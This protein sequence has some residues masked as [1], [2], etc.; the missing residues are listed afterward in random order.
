VSLGEAITTAL[1]ELRAHAESMMTDTVRLE[2][3]TGQSVPDPVTLEVHDLYATDYEGPG[4]VQR[5]AIQPSEHVVGEVEFGTEAAIIQLPISVT[6]AAARQRVTVVSS[7][8]DPAMVG[9]HFTVIGVEMKSHATM[10]RL[11]CEEV[12]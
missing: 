9:A 5:R 8:L 2:H 1:P 10:R 7:L 12:H 6:V 4:R 11:F 3:V